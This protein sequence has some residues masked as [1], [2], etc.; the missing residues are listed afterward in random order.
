MRC[1][2]HYPHEP[3]LRRG[4][5]A[6]RGRRLLVPVNGLAGGQ[7]DVRAVLDIAQ[8][9]PVRPPGHAQ[10]RPGDPPATSY[11]HSSL[12]MPT[13]A[14]AGSPDR[15]AADRCPCPNAGEFI[16]AWKAASSRQRVTTSQ[17]VRP[18]VGLSSSNPSNPS[19]SSTAPA[20]WANLRASSS[21][22]SAGTVI[23]LILT[24]VMPPIMPGWPSGP[25][26]RPPAAMLAGRTGEPITGW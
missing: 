16:Q 20:R 26:C 5:A 2:S 6:V 17:V 24:T 4:T 18:S 7:V 21:P 15:S 11:D 23:A 12:L 10:P 25:A 19:W 13:G 9:R 14:G 1:S 22:L 8:E 3:E